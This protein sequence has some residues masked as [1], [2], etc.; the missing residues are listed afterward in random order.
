MIPAVLS[1]LEIFSS[2]FD[3]LRAEKAVVIALSRNDLNCF[4]VWQS[5]LSEL[6][7]L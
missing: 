4:I 6:L 3:H 7:R 2:R 5:E 1:L